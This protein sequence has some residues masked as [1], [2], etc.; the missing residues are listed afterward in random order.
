VITAKLL[1]P[2]PMPPE[3]HIEIHIARGNNKNTTVEWQLV[4]NVTNGANNAG[5]KIS[6]RINQKKVFFMSR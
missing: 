1:P 2:L 6:P 3:G 4:C 5:K